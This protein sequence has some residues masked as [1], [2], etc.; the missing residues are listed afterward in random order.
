MGSGVTL[1]S[2]A[3]GSRH[4]GTLSF[5]VRS[6]GVGHSGFPE[7]AEESC[8]VPH[9][10]LRTAGRQPFAFL[11]GQASVCGGLVIWT[12]EQR[13]LRQVSTT[14]TAT[15]QPEFDLMRFAS[16]QSKCFYSYSIK[17][18]KAQPRCQM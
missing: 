3:R 6:D 12:L 15:A 5:L 1:G 8:T 10:V 14:T 17:E 7:Q 9:T 16:G 4:K 18:Q 11:F 2:S 13:G